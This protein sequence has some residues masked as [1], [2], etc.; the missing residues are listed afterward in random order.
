MLAGPTDAWSMR[1]LPGARLTTRRVCVSADM[2]H[3][4]FVAR[5]GG[6]GQLDVEVRVYDGDG[7][8]SDAS[9]GSVSASDH[10]T[11]APSRLVASRRRASSR[12]RRATST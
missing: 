10:V 6:G 2:P 4:R 8:V 3:L 5:A 12:T 7:E 9:S 11:W 1:L